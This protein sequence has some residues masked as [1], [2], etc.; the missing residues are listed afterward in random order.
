[1]DPEELQ[2]AVCN[3]F[4]ANQG[5]LVPRLLPENGFTFCTACLQNM[6]DQNAD[7]DTFVCPDDED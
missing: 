3:R 6:L 1:M 4:Y 7:K 5:E 2:C